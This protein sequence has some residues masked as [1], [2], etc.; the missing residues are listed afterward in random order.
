MNRGRELIL[1]RRVLMGACLLA[2]WPFVFS[3]CVTKASAQAQAR[4]AFLAG[5]QQALE[6]M[7]QTQARGP[8]VTFIGQVKNSPIPWTLNLTLAKAIV[9]AEYYGPTDPKQIVLVRDGKEI[10]FDPKTLLSGEDV[11]LQPSDVVEIRR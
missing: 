2:L 5:Q 3:G 9:A 7:Q 6:R 11:P 1:L 10:P 4:A 8:T